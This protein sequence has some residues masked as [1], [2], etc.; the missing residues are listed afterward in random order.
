MKITKIIY[1]VIIVT[2]LVIIC[3]FGRCYAGLGGNEQVVLD[4]GSGA[5][6]GTSVMGDE[7]QGL[8]N[9]R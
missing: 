5:E 9:I 7:S 3:N 6:T 4:G 8:P 2:I 1:K